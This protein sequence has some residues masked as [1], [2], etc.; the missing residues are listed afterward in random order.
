LVLQT[1]QVYRTIFAPETISPERNEH[2]QLQGKRSKINDRDLYP[3]AYSGLVA[4]SS[5]VRTN[6]EIK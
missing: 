3:P 5:A 4:G 1:L 2:D 6:N